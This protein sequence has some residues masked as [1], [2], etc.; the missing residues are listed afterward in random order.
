M[1]NSNTAVQ[2]QGMYV[3]VRQKADVFVHLDCFRITFFKYCLCVSIRV[4]VCSCMHVCVWEFGTCLCLCARVHVCAYVHVCVHV[5][6]YE[7]VFV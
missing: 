5:Y 6:M 1:G 3:Y 7:R 2:L 4:C